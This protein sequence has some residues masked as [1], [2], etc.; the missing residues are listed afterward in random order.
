MNTSADMHNS[1]AF[2]R[3][4][5]SEIVKATPWCGGRLVKRKGTIVLTYD[6]HA[7]PEIFE[8]GEL[9]DAIPYK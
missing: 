9:E 5:V 1:I 3:I 2:L 4:R 7:H 6:D 8:E